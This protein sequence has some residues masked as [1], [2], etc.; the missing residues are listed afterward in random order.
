LGELDFFS[1]IKNFLSLKQI[2]IDLKD[3]FVEIKGFSQLV[4]YAVDG[5]AIG[6]NFVSIFLLFYLIKRITGG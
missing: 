1:F 4:C 3:V 5:I 6:S 2:F